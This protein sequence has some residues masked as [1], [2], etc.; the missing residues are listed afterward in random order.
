MKY[1]AAL[2]ILYDHEKRFLLQHRT[3]DAAVL[4]NYWAFFGGG[5][6]VGE[7]PEDAVRR[8]AFEEL[9]YKLKAPLFFT[10]QD[11]RADD[12]E[13]HMYIYIEAFDGDKSVLKL[14]EGQGWG[15]YKAS[16]IDNLKMVYHDRQLIKSINKYLENDIN[17]T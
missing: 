10:E 12:I 1:K 13:G 9:N 7:T 14:Q 2:I 5:I 16:E 3:N 11:F 4:P 17:V 15:W 6:R 8:E